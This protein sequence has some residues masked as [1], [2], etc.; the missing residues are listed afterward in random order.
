VPT[1]DSAVTDLVLD[2]GTA[3]VSNRGSVVAHVLAGL[4]PVFGAPVVWSVDSIALKD[5]K[6]NAQRGDALQFD[7]PAPNKNPNF[8]QPTHSLRASFAGQQSAVQVVS[9]GNFTATSITADCAAARGACAPIALL[10]LL[11]ARKKK[12]AAPG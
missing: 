1:A 12:T 7:V 10:A 4:E 3:V 8:R 5:D 2:E 6:G 11:L 9:S